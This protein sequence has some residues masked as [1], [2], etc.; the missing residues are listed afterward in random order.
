MAKHNTIGKEG[1]EIAASYLKSKG[2]QILEI[3]KQLGRAEVDIIAKIG[4]EYVFVEVKTRTS[5]Y[6]GFPEESIGKSKINM[7]ASA[8]EKY[9]IEQNMELDIRFD[10]ISLVL[11]GSKQEIIH[12]E[13]AF[14]PDQELF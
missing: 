6:F 14:F 1:E 8:A 4:L 11:E 5:S 9:C 10:L 12:V 7:L 13:D 2:Y 3:N